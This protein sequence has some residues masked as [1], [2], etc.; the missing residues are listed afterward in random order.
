MNRNG[1]YPSSPSESSD[2][3]SSKFSALNGALI[4]QGKVK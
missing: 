3:C 1:V 4:E 2:I